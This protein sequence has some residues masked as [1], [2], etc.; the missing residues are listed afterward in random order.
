MQEERL[1]GVNE[2]ASKE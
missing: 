2:G 1:N